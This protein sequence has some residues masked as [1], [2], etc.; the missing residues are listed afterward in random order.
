MQKGKTI[1]EPKLPQANPHKN[2]CRGYIRVS[3][4]AQADEGISLEDQERKI[5]AWAAYHEFEVAG[6]YADKGITGTKLDKRYQLQK[7]RDDIQAGEVLIAF[8]ISRIARNTIDFLQLVKELDQKGC[9]IFVITGNLESLTNTG[10]LMIGI[11]SLI[12][13]FEAR[14]T[15]EK[16]K[17]ALALKKEK[18]E[19][20]GRIPYG[21]MASNGA[22]SD[23]IEN[24]EEHKT[25]ELIRQLREDQNLS[26]EK[27]A[28]YLTSIGTPPPNKSQKWCHKSISRFYNREPVVTKGKSLPAHLLL[29]NNV[30]NAQ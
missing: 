2:I 18:G 19:R 28:N 14:S 9:H 16:V 17:S 23:L 4:D 15:Q 27:I 1:E 3:T 12:A 22:G 20:V 8:D 29:Q 11:L 30:A 26:Y 5:R 24:P 7:L 10:K 25:L 6:I 21:Y 13:E